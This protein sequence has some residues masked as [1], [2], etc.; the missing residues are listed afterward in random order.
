LTAGTV[1]ARAAQSA[2]E[3][4]SVTTPPGSGLYHWRR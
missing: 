3:A 4:E 1:G 2:A